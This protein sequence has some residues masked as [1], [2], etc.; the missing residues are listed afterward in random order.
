[1]LTFISGAVGVLIASPILWWAWVRETKVVIPHALTDAVANS[2]TV[3]LIE[4]GDSALN[5]PARFERQL[6]HCHRISTSN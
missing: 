2:V 6:V 4:F 3:H 1:M 5:C